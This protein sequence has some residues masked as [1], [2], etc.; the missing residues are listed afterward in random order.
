MSEYINAIIKVKVPE[1][2][3]GEEAQVFFPDTMST[4]GIC[5]EVRDNF[6]IGYAQGYKDGKEERPTGKPCIVIS[7]DM[8]NYCICPCCRKPIDRWDRYCKHCGA[9]MENG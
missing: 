2:Q 9:E 6:D 1:W 3:I 5:E 4:K 7:E 8:G